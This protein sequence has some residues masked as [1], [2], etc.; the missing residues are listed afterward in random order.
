M[1]KK[2]KM[3]SL[4]LCV[5]CMCVHPFKVT[6]AIKLVQRATQAHT[7]NQAKWVQ[8]AQHQLFYPTHLLALP[9]EVDI[10]IVGLT[11]S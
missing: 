11:F 2:K 5:A 7:V 9:V 1:T 6:N 8:D 3:H 10:T 4:L